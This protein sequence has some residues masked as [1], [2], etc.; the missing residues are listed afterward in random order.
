LTPK[1]Q[2]KEISGA[3]HMLPL[4]APTA[5]AATIENWLTINEKEFA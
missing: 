3:G 2:F 1:S 5:F 4:E